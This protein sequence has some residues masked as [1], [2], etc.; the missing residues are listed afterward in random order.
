MNPSTSGW[1]DKYIFILEKFNVSFSNSDE[2]EFYEY[3]KQSGFIYGFSIRPLLN[4][5][6]PSL[7]LSE[8]ELAKLN[9]FHTLL[10]VHFNYHN[11][12]S[13][14]EA[15]RHINEFYGLITPKKSALYPSFSFRLTP[16]KKLE[17]FIKK[18][19]VKG[20]SV[21]NQLFS[22]IISQALLFMDA[23]V[24][25]AYISKGVPPKEYAA[26]LEKTLMQSCSSALQTKQN[27][28][29]YDLLLIEMFE[30]ST[31]GY[32]GTSNQ[33]NEIKKLKLSDYS[34]YFEKHYLLDLST[35]AVWNDFN[36]E[37]AEKEYLQS[38]CSELKMDPAEA[39]KSIENIRDFVTTNSSSIKLF[40]YVHPVKQFYK[41]SSGLVKMLLLRNKKRLT[42]E[43]HQ[44]RELLRLLGKS[45]HANLNADEKSLVK[46]Q[47]TDIFKTIPSL[48]IF[49]LPGGTLLLPLVIKFIPQLLPSAFDDNKIPKK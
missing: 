34:R 7:K 24:Y 28:T 25:Q 42:K 21:D 40:Q 33:N 30:A 20:K 37:P 15:I 36:I 1:I 8:D 44:N 2:N 41:E 23:I 48:T 39:Q 43:I 4:L 35:F 32:S 3:L 22:R 11:T 12:H 10:F 16:S 38:L 19:I 27:K 26:Q 49:L 6:D 5:N 46:E 31:L 45:T 17:L 9:L 29:K 13:F 18:R 14:E 47:L